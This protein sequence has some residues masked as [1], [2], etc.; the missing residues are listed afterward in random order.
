MS[1][2]KD[3]QRIGQGRVLVAGLAAALILLITA[4]AYATWRDVR[5]AEQRSY[6]DT[7]LYTLNMRVSIDER[8]KGRLR[9]WRAAVQMLEER[10]LAGVGIGRYY[11]LVPKYLEDAGDDVIQENAHNYLLQMAAELGLPGM[12]CFLVLLG[13]AIRAGW[14]VTRWGDDEGTRRMAAGLTAGL[15]A[16]ATTCLA[17]HVLLLREGQLTF[18]PLAALTF[19]LDRLSWLDRETAPIVSSRTRWPAPLLA[20]AIVLLFASVPIRII[21][22]FRQLD[23]SRILVGLYDEEEAPDGTRFRWTEPSATLFIPADAATLTLP[24]RTIAPMTQAVTILRD[25]RPV[26]KILLADHAWHE[27]RYLLAG[28]KSGQR[29]HR[30]DIHVSPTWRPG[31]DGRE[32]GIMLGPYRWSR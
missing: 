4:S 8:L 17:A 25:G 3:G 15:L 2:G 30:F 16:L 11:K 18:W 21:R 7:A 27:P 9:F 32:I 14:R 12:V 29:F 1:N 31:N 6:L 5:H 10:P 19:R 22:D 26:D 13:S 23:L 24:M 20:A 28:I